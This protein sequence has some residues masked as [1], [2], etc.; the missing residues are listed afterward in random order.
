[1]IELFTAA[2]PNG[3]KVAITLEELGIPYKVHPIA[4]GE[5][6]HKQDWYAEINPNGKIPSIIDHDSGKFPV[7]ESGAIMHYLAER[8]KKLM[9]VDPLGRS[10]VLQWLMLQMAAIGPM[11]G[12]AAVF[13]KYAPE[14]IPFAIDRYTRE[15]TRLL[16]VLDRRLDGREFLCGE[17]SIADIAH[18]SWV[19]THSFIGIEI[20][21]FPHL[22][23]WIDTIAARPAVIKGKAVPSAIDLAAISEEELAAR[24]SL[25]A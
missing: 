8:E 25:L 24:R 17:Y 11:M 4:L 7:F 13:L 3:W 20:H 12:Q 16:A 2:T 23:R 15:V 21:D 1:M 9:P 5:G 22:Q 14:P 6:V 19:H 10:L 18:W